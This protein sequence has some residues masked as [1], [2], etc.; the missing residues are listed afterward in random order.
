MLPWQIL[1]AGPE[2]GLEPR[3]LPG[4]ARPHILAFPGLNL[5]R[6]L[7]LTFPPRSWLRSKGTL[8]EGGRVKC[9]GSPPPGFMNEILYFHLPTE[10]FAPSVIAPYLCPVILHT[11]GSPP[12]WGQQLCAVLHLRLGSLIP[13]WGRERGGVPFVEMETRLTEVRHL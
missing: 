2:A 8:G 10:S 1:P 13:G 3:S 9:E 7:L 5:S 4:T 12:P 6:W 11:M